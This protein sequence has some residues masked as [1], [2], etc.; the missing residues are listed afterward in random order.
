MSALCAFFAVSGLFAQST[1]TERTLAARTGL[2]L[3][4][5]RDLI[6]PKEGTPNVTDALDRVR[7]WGIVEVETAGTGNLTATEFRT[8]LDA[9]GL[10][11]VSSHAGYGALEKDLAGVIATAKTLGASYIVCPGIPHKAGEFNDAAAKKAAENFNQWAAACRAAG[12]Q[13]AY[14]PHGFE[15]S[16]SQEL[17]GQR[18]FD[19]L[20]RATDPT[21]MKYQMDV[22]WVYHAG[23][24]PVELLKKYPDRWVTL[25]IKD[26]RKGAL[27]A[28]D[29]GVKPGSTPPTDKVPVGTGEIDWPAVY[30]TAESLG[31]KH[32]FIEDEGLKPLDEI[33]RSLAYVRAL[34]PNND[35]A[36]Q[37]QPDAAGWISLDA[38]DAWRTY[39]DAGNP[40][41]WKFANGEI[42]S[43]PRAG[44]LAT[45]GEFSDFEL[46]LE[47]KISPLG[48]SGVMFRVKEAPGRA[49]HQTGPEM[50]VL[51]DANQ[52]AG[53]L[54]IHR[55]GALYGLYEPSAPM[56]K[57]VGEWNQARLIQRGAHVEL[58]LNGTK[59]AEA[60]IGSADWKARVAASKFAPWEGFAMSQRGKIVL[61]DH[62]DPVSFRHLRIRPLK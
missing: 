19:V 53:K 48:N 18:V 3:W 50:Q 11:A 27:R 32:A 5:L 22:F 28:G 39:N 61:Q 15:F 23:V 56:A 6:N 16:P 31:V 24:D 21:L 8:Q 17:P 30:A 60:E 36:W 38:P 13:F 62:S 2:Q 7:D 46:E 40:T 54:V 47:W 51:D 25:H 29:T 58:W 55:A 59:T 14:H 57:P 45:K 43:Q 10:K 34:A 1:A 33:P 37:P 12:I 41:R 4:S 20:I 52:K 42:S 26:L 49:S 9:R 35:A 44:D